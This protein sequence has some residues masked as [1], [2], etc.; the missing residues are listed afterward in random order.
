MKWYL[1]ELNSFLHKTG[2]Q[3]NLTKKLSP[4]FHHLD[5]LFVIENLSVIHSLLVHISQISKALLKHLEDER[6]ISQPVIGL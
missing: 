5:E 4:P 3:G 2:K 1:Y 6:V